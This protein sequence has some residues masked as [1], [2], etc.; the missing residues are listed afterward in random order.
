MR[1]GHAREFKQTWRKFLDQAL[2]RDRLKTRM[3]RR[4]FDGNTGTRRQ[5]GI[6]RAGAD[7]F[8]R[9]GISRK[10]LFSIGGCTRAFAE[11][12]ERVADV[13]V[14]AGAP[15]RFLDGLPEY[16][17]RADQ[18]HGLARRRAQCRQAKAADDGVENRLWRFARVDDACGDAKRP[19]R[20]RDEKRGGF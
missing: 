14:R 10:I 2:A 1:F 17:V 6:A 16:E 15:E 18:P 3:Q 12:V 7:R 8:N 19:R 20:R 11:H 5:R 4:E 13:A 9:A